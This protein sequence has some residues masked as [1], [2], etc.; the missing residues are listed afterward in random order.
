[1]EVGYLAVGVFFFL[2]GYGLH[3]SLKNKSGYLK[4]F[5]PKRYPS[6]LLPYYI[7]GIFSAF[8]AFAAFSSYTAFFDRLS[9]IIQIPHWYVTELL[10]FYTLF[11]I[12]FLLMRNRRALIST[13][14]LS[15]LAAYALSVCFNS[16]LYYMSFVGFPLGL[17]WS[18]Y[19]KK[20]T[21]VL[22]KSFVPIFIALLIL[23][24]LPY[25]MWSAGGEG[26]GRYDTSAGLQHKM[27]NIHIN[28]H[29][30]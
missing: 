21:T 12:S 14:A 19:S 16:S 2:S 7:C 27:R 26:G 25:E 30:A 15:V 1:M 22:K 4:T 8:I 18:Y 6:V 9:F 3:E 11:L 23:F 29:N 28:D 13:I 5:I 17:V 10:V 24:L 20:I